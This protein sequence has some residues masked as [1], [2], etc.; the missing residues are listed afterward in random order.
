MSANRNLLFK[1]GTIGID[2]MRTQPMQENESGIAKYGSTVNQLL[3][4]IGSQTI[5]YLTIIKCLLSVR[6]YK[7]FIVLGLF[8][9]IGPNAESN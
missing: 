6:E 2:L 3:Q 1:V 8:H 4:N 7:S 5:M 9:R